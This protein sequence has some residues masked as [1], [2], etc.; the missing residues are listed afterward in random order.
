MNEK[1][2]KAE[3]LA[4]ASCFESVKAAY[5]AG[6]DAVYIGGLKFGARA[7]ADNM[8]EQELLGAI[9]YAHL[10][11]RKIY[12][13]VNTLLKNSELKEELYNYL[14]PYYECGLDAVIVQDLGVMSFVK[15]VFPNMPIHASTQMSITGKYMPCFLEK[16]GIERI[17]TARELSLQEINAIHKAAPDIEIES[18]VH[19]ALCMGYSGMCFFSSFLGER[20]G[21][22]GR[23]AQACRLPYC[24]LDEDKN[25]ITEFE[26]KRYALSPKDICTINLLPQIIEAGVYS[27]K[28][29]GR[30]KRIEYTAG[31]TS[32]YRKY[33][34]LYLEKGISNYRVSDEDMNILAQLYNRGG[35]SEGYYKQKNGKEMMSFD[36]PNHFG[37]YV[38]TV[39]YHNNKLFMKTT[40][41]LHKS[42]VLEIREE[43]I[44]KRTDV[45][46]NEFTVNN[47]VKKNETIPLP[48]S[49]QNKRRL[50]KAPVYRMKDTNLLNQI[51]ERYLVTDKI[52]LYAKLFVAENEEIE[53]WVYY[54]GN[55]SNQMQVCDCL[56]YNS[57]IT[58]RGDVVQ[59][60]QTQCATEEQLIKNLNKTGQTEFVFEK[61]DIELTGNCFVPVKAINELRRK[62]IDLILQTYLRSYQRSTDLIKMKSFDFCKKAPNK[63]DDTKFIDKHSELYVNISLPE[64]IDAVIKFKEVKGCYVD[65]NMFNIDTESQMYINI[66]VK[67]LEAGIKFFISLPVILREEHSDKIINNAAWIFENVDGILVHNAEQ[68][69]FVNMLIEEKII[70]EVEIVSDYMLYSMNDRSIDFLFQNNVKRYTM[71]V[72]LTQNELKGL[73]VYGLYCS[74]LIFYGYLP[75]MFTA[76][77]QRKNS[78]RC[79]HKVSDM[80]L[81]DRKGKNLHVRTNC[82]YCYNTIYNSAP[83]SLFGLEEN[84]KDINANVLRLHFTNESKAM[85]ESIIQSFIFRYYGSKSLCENNDVLSEFTRGHFKRGVE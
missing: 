10:H 4:P 77:C 68:L 46:Y 32:I 43:N 41:D 56:D 24:L 51:N 42:D 49:L 39:N 65:F 25:V 21:N 44:D 63:P 54:Y 61:I 27:L 1:Q 40:Q 69:A 22:R 48:I 82:N 85:T 36:R 79:T 26:N 76:Q 64:Q 81:E 28:I 11:G 3:L 17:V 12:M 72:E 37:T 35:F 20:S 58:V 5:N 30:M 62:A 75:M 70:D 53:L 2:V 66:K 8:N 52:P 31:V 16:M 80:F 71:P 6:A 34:D 14:L 7:Y 19:G 78:N 13:T 60:A 83:F 50:N 59:S 29:E 45:R 23:C 18:F 47:D 15:E 84:V 57:Y 74:E 55:F 9:D 38:G 73:D 33:L 67:I